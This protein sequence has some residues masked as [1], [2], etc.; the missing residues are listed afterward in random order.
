MVMALAPL[1]SHYGF[2]R[3]DVSTYQS[4][5]GSGRAGIEALHTQSCAI[6]NAKTVPQH[7]VYPEGIG[8]NCVPCIGALLDNGYTDEEM[9]M[10][11]ESQKILGMPALTVNATA[12]RVP[13]FYGHAM[14]V[15]VTMDQSFALDDIKALWR[16][17]PGLCY[18]EAH[19]PTPSLQAT[20]ND[21]VWIGRAR[22]DLGQQN[23][24][25]FWVVTDNL[26]KGAVSNA[27]DILSLLLAEKKIKHKEAICGT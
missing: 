25:N 8:F 5:S 3:I 13:V 4:V 2:H 7:D 1:R 6:L 9:K 18:V 26:R 19:G 24:L 14:T 12:V 21:L 11:H 23:D 16:K 20:G 10:H 27:M 22:R 17:T 15:H